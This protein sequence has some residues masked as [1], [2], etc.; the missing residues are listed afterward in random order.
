META[1]V[2]LARELSAGETELCLKFRGCLNDKMHGFYRSSYKA[3][4]G[5][6]KKMFTTQFE[7]PEV[8][9]YHS[10]KCKAPP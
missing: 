10:M 5:S 9:A 8:E 4:D 1:R 3:V 7:V 6:D 2:D